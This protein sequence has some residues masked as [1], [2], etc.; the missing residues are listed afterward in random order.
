MKPLEVHKKIDEFYTKGV[1]VALIEDARLFISNSEDSKRYFFSKAGELWLEWFIKNSLFDELKKPYGDGALLRYRLPELEYLLRMAHLAPHLV[2]K[3]I[4]SIPVS[5]KNLNLE[6]IDRFFWI[7]GELPAEQIKA[8][9]PKIKRENWIK[10]MLPLNRT[11]NYY[12]DM[13]KKLMDAGDY[14]SLLVLAE[15]V[16]TVRTKKDFPKKGKFSFSDKPFYLNNISDVGIFEIATS[17]LNQKRLEYLRVFLKSLTKVVN[18]GGRGRTNVFKK[19]EPFYLMDVDIFTLELD[20]RK[21]SHF[22]EDM[23]NLVAACKV[24]INLNL[25]LQ[26][27]D[28][29]RKI[30]FSEINVMPDSLTCWRLKLYAITRRPETFKA[31]ITEALFRVFN[32][33]ERYFEIDGGAEYHQ[34]LIAGFRFLDESVRREYVEKVIEYYGFELEDKDK[35]KWRRRDGVEILSYIKEHITADEIKMAEEKLG[36][37][38]DGTKIAPHPSIGEITSGYVSH[39]SPFEINSMTIDELI[40]RLRTD[41]NPS[42]LNELY[43]GDNFLSPRGAEGLGEKIKE[44][45]V[46]RKDEYLKN[47]NKFFDRNLIDPVYVY[48]ILR[49]VEDMFRAKEVFTHEQYSLIL[50]FFSLIRKSGEKEEFK[51]AS[52]NS[53]IADWI[54]VHKSMA[55]I[56]LEIL[57]VIKGSEIFTLNR[58]EIL[59]LVKYLL[60]IQSS[61]DIEDDKRES[62]DPAHVAINSVRGQAYRAFVQ[63]AYNDDDVGLSE[64][65]KTLYEHTLNTETSNA[66]RFTMGQ[67]L[68]SFYFRDKDFIRKLLPKIFPTADEINKDLY[69]STWEGYLSGSLYTGLFDELQGY[70]EHAIKTDSSSYPERKYLKGLDETLGVHLALAYSHLDLKIGDSLFNLFWE[71]SNETRHYEF[72]SFIGRT[73]INRNDSGDKWFIENKVSKEKLIDFWNWIISTDIK[74]EPKAFSGFGFWINPDKEIIESKI[75]VKNIAISLER[76]EGDIDWDYGLVRQM[77]NFAE[78]DPKNTLLIMKNFLLL[79]EGL[80]PHRG[81]PLFSIDNEIKDSLEIVYKNNSMKS[82]VTEFVDTLIERGSSTFWGL[83]TILK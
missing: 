71:T 19:S 63:F 37:L 72:V 40:I 9:L 60:S 32:A 42:V 5:K 83:K 7:T 10:L 77:C 12:Q 25:S 67:F 30:Y 34:A 41:A 38:L 56:L 43:K 80:N 59:S 17:D 62:G 23:Q 54:T 82:V 58:E 2:T 70:Y 18:L 79:G 33:G 15:I 8:I 74:I 44:D 65:V 6:V 55:D 27:E 36:D 46:I 24:L 28:S 39:K 13:V 4:L 22:R 3:V 57:A 49:K 21:R 50:S 76:S 75:A 47:I 1:A 29:A 11:G 81:V 16:L 69:F 45:L 66:V 48:A 51:P 14:D 73:C 53:H 26:T 35:Q 52:Q 61:P 68:A 78:I 64:S 20:S 31:E